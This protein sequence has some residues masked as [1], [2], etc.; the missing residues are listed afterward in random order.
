MIVSTFNITLVLY[1]LGGSS[2]VN[3]VN[4]GYDD[5]F[6]QSVYVFEDGTIYLVMYDSDDSCFYI[7]SILPNGEVKRLDL[8]LYKNKI[9]LVVDRLNFYVLDPENN[10]IDI[11]SKTTFKKLSELQI[12]SDVSDLVLAFGM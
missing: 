8:P 10:R 7:L 9:Y 12:E 3:V 2:S 1:D 4:H 5:D 6:I 11:Y